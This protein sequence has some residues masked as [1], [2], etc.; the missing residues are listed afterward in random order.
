LAKVGWALGRAT[1]GGV[2]MLLG[3]LLTTL[4]GP[5]SFPTGAFAALFVT[6]TARGLNALP[7]QRF[8]TGRP[9]PT[10]GRLATRLVDGD[11]VLLAGRTV[12]IDEDAV[13]LGSRRMGRHQ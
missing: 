8:P 3:T 4:G 9:V 2:A 10:S 13:F 6:G 12:G 11:G 1:V 5:L 7:E